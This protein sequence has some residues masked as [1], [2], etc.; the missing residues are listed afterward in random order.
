MQTHAFDLVIIDRDQRHRVS[1]NP[2]QA[3]D[4]AQSFGSLDRRFDVCQLLMVGMVALSCLDNGG[5][6]A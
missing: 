3:T 6:H 1:G 4:K 5:N 2:F